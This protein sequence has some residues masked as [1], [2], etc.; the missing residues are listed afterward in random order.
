M[1]ALPYLFKEHPGLSCL[2]LTLLTAYFLGIEP[3]VFDRWVEKAVARVAS[4]R[5]R[6]HR[7]RRY[8]VLIL[9]F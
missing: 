7:V 9:V 3:I 5:I 8:I 1:I 4:P 6:A 2:I